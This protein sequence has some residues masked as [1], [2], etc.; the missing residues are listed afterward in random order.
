MAARKTIRTLNKHVAWLAAI[1]SLVAAYSAPALF[2]Q[3]PAEGAAKKPGRLATYKD[4]TCGVKFRYPKNWKVTMPPPDQEADQDK[5]DCQFLIRPPNFSQLMR[6]LDVDLYSVEVELINA[7]FKQ[8]AERDYFKQKGNGVWVALN[9]GEMEGMAE[10]F[11][12]GRIRGLRA[13]V[14]E[15]CYH[16]HGGYAGICELMRAVLNNGG[17]RSATFDAGPQAEYEFQIIL[18]SFK[19]FPPSRARASH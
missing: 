11:Q 5:V 13:T 16:E 12:K 19:F 15:R 10:E 14:T 8:E 3:S 4:K 1:A 2:A 9:M 18:N 17:N 7:D 6:E